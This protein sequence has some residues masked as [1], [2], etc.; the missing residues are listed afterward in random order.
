MTPQKSAAAALE[1]LRYKSFRTDQQ[2][3]KTFLGLD[4]GLKRYNTK[5][6]LHDN[7]GRMLQLDYH[8]GMLHKDWYAAAIMLRDNDLLKRTSKPQ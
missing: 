1:W 8:P 2:G 3:N 4:A 7:P 5:E 6:D